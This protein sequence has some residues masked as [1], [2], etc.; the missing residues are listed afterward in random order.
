MSLSADTM[1]L[2]D[3]LR[4]AG[5]LTPEE[6]RTYM[7]LRGLDVNRV[8]LVPRGANK[9]RFAIVKEEGD[10]MAIQND[11]GIG[12]AVVDTGDGGFV[13]TDDPQDIAKATL[14][15]PAKAAMLKSLNAASS[16]LA[17]LVEK[18]NGANSGPPGMDVPP[19]FG[20]EA[21]A[22]GDM[23]SAAAGAPSSAGAGGEEKQNMSKIDDTQ[24]AA[25]PKVNPDAVDIDGAVIDHDALVPVAKA[26]RRMSG[27]TRAKFKEYLTGMQEI[28]R[29]AE[30]NP[31]DAMAAALTEAMAPV[32]KAF[33][34]HAEQQGEL[35]N[36]F[37]ALVQKALGMEPEADPDA[38]PAAEGGDAK[39][40]GGKAPVAKSA[41]APTAKPDPVPA[42]QAKPAASP[43]AKGAEVTWADVCG[44][45][46]D[47]EE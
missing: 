11:D 14:P 35:I 19:E 21:K 4:R 46:L 31:G 43:V 44:V 26:G 28:L 24:P 7:R 20:R 41:P 34:D 32:A 12:P 30:K 9:R 27:A 38:A 3:Q 2:F 16:R 29:D 22:I 37:M 8:D 1:G 6:E 23:I 15:G 45:P 39:P 47:D 18:V 36:G 33:S 13:L 25:E 17:A 40:E 42:G 5:R 10:S